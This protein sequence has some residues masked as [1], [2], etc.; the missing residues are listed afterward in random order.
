MFTFNFSPRDVEFILLTIATVFAHIE[1]DSAAL[2]Y[3]VENPNVF[4]VDA[5]AIAANI[6]Q[7]LSDSLFGF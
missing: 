6:N 3:L 7:Q 2:N 5:E 4:T 1:G